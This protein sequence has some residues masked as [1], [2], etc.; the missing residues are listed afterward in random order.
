MEICPGVIH[1]LLNPIRHGREGLNDQ[2]FRVVYLKDAISILEG[3]LMEQNLR[4][5]IE[6]FILY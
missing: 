2:C 3:K 5:V 1:A 6:I 4:E